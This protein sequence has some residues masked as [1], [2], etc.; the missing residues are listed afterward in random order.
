MDKIWFAGS[1]EFKGHNG[2]MAILK[3]QG[4]EPWGHVRS[5]PVPGVTP[6]FLLIALGSWWKSLPRCM[7]G[8]VCLWADIS[9]CP[10]DRGSEL[11]LPKS[12]GWAQSTKAEI[13]PGSVGAAWGPLGQPSFPCCKEPF[14]PSLSST[15]PKCFPWNSLKV[16][17]PCFSP[18]GGWSGLK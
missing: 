6:A 8:N 2:W 13:S 5:V 7:C 11:H 17:A 18:K 9:L 1:R 16:S 10:Q 12:P 15:T 4:R 3:M 14:S